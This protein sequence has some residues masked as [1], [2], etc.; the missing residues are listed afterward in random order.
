METFVIGKPNVLEGS[1]MISYKRF[2][3]EQLGAPDTQEVIWET[4][5]GVKVRVESSISQ[6]IRGILVGGF[7]TGIV[8]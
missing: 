8:E 7:E 5:A 4:P 3:G 1:K 2:P 6:G